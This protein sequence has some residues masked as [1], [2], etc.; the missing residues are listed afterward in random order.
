MSTRSLGLLFVTALACSSQAPPASSPRASSPAAPA[1]AANQDN[2]EEPAVFGLPAVVPRLR[3]MPDLDGSRGVIAR[4]EEGELSLVGR[5]RLRTSP[6]GL[7]ER[8]DELLP[9]GRIVAQRVPSRLGGG[10]LF[11]AITPRGSELWRSD[12]W[13]GTL[14]P[15]AGFGPVAHNERPVTMGFDRIYLRF[16]S[17]NELVALDPKTGA[18]LP[19]GP[20]PIA[21][22]FGEMIFLD[23][24]R[25]IVDTDLAGTM[26][27]FDAGATWRRVPTTGRVRAITSSR[28]DPD[29]GGD[30][31]V[32]LDSGTV[33]VTPEGHVAFSPTAVATAS[34]FA[35]PPGS[36]Q[37]AGRKGNKAPGPLGKKPLRVALERGYPDSLNTA[38]VAS[39]GAL[40]RVSLETGAVLDTVKHAYPDAH[41]ECTGIALASR[42][43]A[44]PT[45][46]EDSFG[47]VCGSPGGP[48]AIYAFERPLK[49]RQVMRFA[50]P[51]TVVES[52]QGAIVVRGACADNDDH[53]ETRPFCIRFADGSTREVRIRGDVGA[54]R[55]VAL[56]DG[57]VVILVPPRLGTQGQISILSGKDSKHVVLKMPESGAPREVE[58]GM[59][60]EGFHQTAEDEISGWVEAGGP[61]FGVSIKLDGTLSLG[62]IVDEPNGVLIGGR[63]ALAMRAN[64]PML[65]SVDTGKTWKEIELPR[66]DE[67]GDQPRGRRCSA[68]GC[69]LPGWQKIG[70][71]TTAHEDD[72]RDAPAPPTMK[73]SSIKTPAGPLALSCSFA[74]VQPKAKAQAKKNE[75]SAVTGW[76]PLWSSDPPPMQK[77]EVGIDSGSPYD[78]VPMRAYVWGKKD[79]DW[80]RTGRLAIR[81]MDKFSLEEISSSAVTTS[82]WA[83]ESIASDAFGVGMYSGATASWL[84]QRDQ[85]AALVS[86]C[87]SGRSCSLFAVEPNQ[88]VLTLRPAEG[89]ALPRPFN[90]SAV[91]VGQVWFFLADA[92]TPDQI[93]LYRSDLGRIRSVVSLRRL[94]TPRFSSAP[95]PRLV[96]R[97]KGDALGLMFTLREG[98]NDKRGMRY[99]LPIDPDTG[100]VGDAVRLG[101]PDLA[102]MEVSAACGERDGWVVEL[103]I[104]PSPYVTFDESSVSMDSV[105]LRFRMDPGKACIEV[106]AGATTMGGDVPTKKAPQSGKSATSVE[107]FP[108]F[109][110]DRSTGTRSEM[111]CARVGTK[112]AQDFP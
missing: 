19:Y 62:E 96:R 16:S 37:D 53:S 5:M 108:L 109:V 60:L 21:P 1:Q 107:R 58:T 27:T 51:R 64:G 95:L 8:A 93:M 43:S 80:S 75:G 50:Q 106:G 28:T 83:S 72:L 85:S 6:D 70:W 67:S 45:K 34:P 81:Y 49:L 29:D 38:V 69:V 24:W 87:K 41:A 46:P 3:F 90:G 35:T 73:L 40:V 14:Q 112:G 74:R 55:V 39:E 30:G 111:T 59:W 66:M 13:L 10:F 84:A 33:R 78:V 82:P 25:A 88:P 110:S 91:R 100:E 89:S 32:Q 26:A 61:T 104:E 22:A 105:E 42:G 44:G 17:A 47:F 36:Q 52:G 71:G 11:V 92:G 20:L 15:L 48:T 86:V 31:I 12:A 57:R 4:T 9:Q 63:F 2:G 7:V 79:S 54:E 97:T 98:P 102:D 94:M 99:V 68:V 77:G 18:I 56:A 65:E 23:G 101:R 103:P 76:L